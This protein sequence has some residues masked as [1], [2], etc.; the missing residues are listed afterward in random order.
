MNASD[1]EVV[2]IHREHSGK[3]ELFFIHRQPIAEEF[4]Q[5]VAEQLV[6]GEWWIMQVDNIHDIDN[7]NQA[8]V[9][10]T[11]DQLFAWSELIAEVPIIPDSFVE[12]YDEAPERITRLLD[13]VPMPD[14]PPMFA[15][16]DAKGTTV[17]SGLYP[18]PQ[19]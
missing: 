12:D 13:W 14:R 11:T 5:L 4:P 17:Y 2:E 7:D 8:V 1:I 16:R 3:K 9:V 6:N 10:A 19:R 18:A 15:Y